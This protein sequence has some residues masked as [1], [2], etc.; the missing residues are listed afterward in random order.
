MIGSFSPFG[1]KKFVDVLNEGRHIWGSVSF[2]LSAFGKSDRELLLHIH[3]S[4]KAKSINFFALGLV[5]GNH[6]FLKELAVD[7]LN[8]SPIARHSSLLEHDN[9]EESLG[10]VPKVESSLHLVSI[11]D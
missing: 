6:A 11:I 2:F 8:R 10:K 3:H 4:F 1:L 7:P 9:S 5:A